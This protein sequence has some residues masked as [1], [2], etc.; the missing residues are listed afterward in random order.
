MGIH[1]DWT[2]NI[3]NLITGIPALLFLVKMYGDWRLIKNRIDL[4]W[5]DYCREHNIQPGPAI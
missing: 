3:W 5:V 2:I 4:M 1:L